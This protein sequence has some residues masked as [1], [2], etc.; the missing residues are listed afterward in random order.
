MSKKYTKYTSL[1]FLIILFVAAGILLQRIKENMPLSIMATSP[2]TI[3]SATPLITPYTAREAMYYNK[4]GKGNVQC[5]LCFRRCIITPGRRGFCKNRHNH[6]GTLYS[7]V[8][9]R[10]SAVQVDPVEKEPQYHFMP[11]TKILCIGTAGCNFTC[12]HCHNWHLSQHSIE[13]IRHYDL[14]PADAV[15]HALRLGIPTISFTYNDPIVFYEYVYDIARLAK[16]NNL[17]IIWHSNGSMEKAPLEALLK[18]T[19]AVTIDLKGFSKKAYDNS[20]AELEPVLETL[21]TI[22][23]RGVWLEIVNLIIP[24]INDN[25]EEIKQMCEWIRDNLGK[26]VPLHFSRFYPSYKLRNLPATPIRTI[27]EAFDIAKESGLEY[28]SIGNVPGHKYNSTF[29]PSCDKR[30]IHRSHFNVHSINIKDAK[31]AFC[32]HEIPG[33]WE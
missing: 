33:V 32:G 21:K 28:V 30:I 7:I 18:Y 17:N 9:G 29:C 12:K 1:L 25:P 24:T 31:C 11:G 3:S 10:P 27:E 23:A 6:E 13:E 19:D 4:L 20:Q 15:G 14:S 5:L 22:K 26:D 16:E 2:D 8:Y